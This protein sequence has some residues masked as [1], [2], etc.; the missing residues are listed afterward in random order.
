MGIDSGYDRQREKEEKMSPRV[1]ITS[2]SGKTVET[3]ISKEQTA[4]IMSE[5]YVGTAWV[6]VRNNNGDQVM[7]NGKTVEVIEISDGE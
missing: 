6:G 3:V 7:I 4:K 1:R 5:L 2:T